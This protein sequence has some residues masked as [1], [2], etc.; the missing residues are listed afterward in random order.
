MKRDKMNE[1]SI[2][3]RNFLKYSTAATLGTCLG[4]NL[5][6]Q[7]FGQQVKYLTIGGSTSAG[8]WTVE[9]AYIGKLL[10]E[11][12]PG[13][14]ATGVVNAAESVG[15]CKFIHTKQYQMGKA[16]PFDVVRSYN[17]QPPFEQKCDISLWQTNNISI[18][19]FVADK[20]IKSI[21]ELKGKK[22][23]LNFPGTTETIYTKKILEM[24]G[25]K[26]GDYQGLEVGK[27]VAKQNLIDRRIDAIILSLTRNNQGHLGPVFSARKDLHFIPED[28]GIAKKFIKEY[29]MFFIDCGGQP[30]FNQPD[31]IN[32]AWYNTWICGNYLD[33]ELVYKCTK[34]IFENWDEVLRAIPWYK[35]D[36]IDLKR[37]ASMEIIPFHPGARRY[38]KE[39]G[40]L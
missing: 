37:A 11:K 39:K 19:N 26:E 10:T 5:V 2:S 24:Y 40:V 7:S 9:V 34:V 27:S 8:R 36:G 28:E 12:I 33:E 18:W 23:G 30:V 32:T 16:F 25:L 13:I 22:I 21:S 20:S 17:G 4:T 35:E 3:R 38:Y 31:I 6:Q 1:K 29:P 15:N 14:R